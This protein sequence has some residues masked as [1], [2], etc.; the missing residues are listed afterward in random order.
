MS[1]FDLSLFRPFCWTTFSFIWSLLLFD[2]FHSILVRKIILFSQK[3]HF[4]HLWHLRYSYDFGLV[5]FIMMSTEHN[6]EP[7]SRQYEWLENDLKKVDRKKTPWVLIGG[8]RA[9]YASQ[10]EYGE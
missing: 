7:G 9:M 6:F 10:D 2:T 8:H 5:H 1:E 4:H 3:M